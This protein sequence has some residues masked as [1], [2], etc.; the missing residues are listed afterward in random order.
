MEEPR[1]KIAAHEQ[2]LNETSSEAIDPE[3]LVGVTLGGRYEVKSPLGKGGMGVVYLASQSALNREVV[4]K[5]LG[6]GLSGEGEAMQR[7][8]REAL[9]LSKLTHPNIVTIYDFGRDL[10]QAYIVMEYVDGEMLGELMARV[11]HM[12][13]EL[14]APVAAQI[15]AALAEAHDRGIIHRDIKPSNIMLT[16][17]HGSPNFVKVLDF[18]LVKLVG[19]AQEVTKKQNLVGSVAFLAPEQI[20]GL[21]FDQRADVYALGVLFYYM[22]CGT[23]PF[24]GEDDIAVL[25]QHIHKDADDLHAVLPPDHDIPDLLIDLV[26][27]CLSKEPLERPVDARAMLELMQG[28]DM[29]ATFALPWSSGEFAAVSRDSAMAARSGSQPAIIPQ[30]E[31]TPVSQRQ[32]PTLGHDSSGSYEPISEASLERAAQAHVPTPVALAPPA[33]I[34]MEMAV[35]QAS[36]NRTLLGGVALLLFVLIAG[37]GMLM[38]WSQQRDPAPVKLAPV[39]SSQ[40]R[41]IELLADVDELIEASRWGPAEALLD[42]LKQGSPSSSLLRRVAEREDAIAVGR[43]LQQARVAEQ[44]QERETAREHY[45]SILAHIPS[46]PVASK[47]LAEFLAQD[48][49]QASQMGK[50]NVLTTP[51]GARVFLDDMELGQ[52]PLD[53]E[54]ES[55][56]YTLRF[57]IKGYRSTQK[58]VTLKPGESARLDTTLEPTRR[59]T[60]KS[61][62][63]TSPGTKPKKKPPKSDDLLIPVEKPKPPRRDPGDDLLPVGN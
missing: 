21:E 47:K 7:F 35:A 25:Y 39:I 41:D 37:V 27:R 29:R 6:R 57:E 9:G 8:E 19:D 52:T 12:S 44:N 4:V 22:L 40:D 11:G 48:R 3:A 36:S 5:V 56:E 54:L 61:P 23:K 15:L 17:R 38:F 59:S 51:E 63:K 28:M 18:G 55:G 26:H 46:H 14:F 42:N 33:A 58:I 13:F 49:Q 43:L 20:L 60:S 31:M 34:S 45:Q 62:I 53:V 50:L 16:E 1:E 32:I 24:V 2:T 10:E 30:I